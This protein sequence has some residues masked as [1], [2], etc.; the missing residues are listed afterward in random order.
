[1]GGANSRMVKEIME[2]SLYII[3]QTNR[4]TYERSVEAHQEV[5]SKIEELREMNKQMIHSTQQDDVRSEL[6]KTLQGVDSKK[7]QLDEVVDGFA[8]QFELPKSYQKIADTHRID[9]QK[10]KEAAEAAAKK[11]DKL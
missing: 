6:F 2:D 3:R 4:A 5:A 8:K 9:L 11:A 10:V 1:M 7:K